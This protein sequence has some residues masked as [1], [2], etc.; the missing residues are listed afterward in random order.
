MNDHSLLRQ[1]LAAYARKDL[2][3]IEAMLAEEVTLQDWNLAV[4]GKAAVLRETR[5]NFESARSIA[6]EILREF[7]NGPDSAAELRITVDDSIQ[8]D[9]VDIV[10]VNTHGL[11]ESIKSYKG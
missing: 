10:R 5:N 1:Y 6:I 7:D 11:V 3:A 2:D 4:K 8:L 9:V